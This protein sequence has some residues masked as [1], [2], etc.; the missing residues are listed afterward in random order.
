MTATDIRVIDPAE[1]R[2]WLRAEQRSFGIEP[3]EQRLDELLD[4]V[5]PARSFAAIDGTEIVATGAA[6]ATRV[7]LPG[8]ASVPVGGISAI[9]TRPT[10]TRQGLFRDIMHHLHEQSAELGEPATA[11]LAS[12]S[13]L[14]DRFGYGL[15]T[16]ATW[17]RIESR[18]ASLRGDAPI[19]DRIE[20]FVPVDTAHDLIDDIWRQVAGR[21]PGWLD[22]PRPL[23]DLV[24]A[25]HAADRDGAMPFTMAVHR[26]DDGTPDGYCLYRRRPQQEMGH[27]TGSVHVRELVG[28]DAARLSLWHHLLSIDLVETIEAMPVPDDDPLP[29]AL[30]D[31]R[32]FR[33]VGVI[34][35]LWLRPH[36]IATLLSARRYQ[37]ADRLVLDVADV[38]RFAIEGGPDDATVTGTDD[39]ADLGLSRAELATVVVGRSLR[40]L[41]SAG[42]VHVTDDAALDR[43]DRFV[44]WPV[45]P[46]CLLDF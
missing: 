44:R 46:Y 6:F 15:A 26:T 30:V 36:D 16:T 39:P 29:L 25:D 3:S 27:S 1:V 33:T 4:V 43:W 28:S 14:Y 37:V 32:Q 19:T 31:P 11:L 9:G 42:R 12:E 40:P 38:G 13:L 10:H 20:M 17:A 5:D 41:V 18:R 34:D 2:A 22:R 24:L 21:R 45:A 23:L 8:G 7:H 35:Q